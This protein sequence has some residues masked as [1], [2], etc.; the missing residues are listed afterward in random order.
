MVVSAD[1]FCDSSGI[2]DRGV[3]GTNGNN[4]GWVRVDLCIH[5]FQCIP[6]TP[7]LP[8]EQQVAFWGRR[9]YVG[10][11]DGQGEREAAAGHGAGLCYGLASKAGGRFPDIPSIFSRCPASSACIVLQHKVDWCFPQECHAD[12]REWE[13]ATSFRRS[14]NFSHCMLNKLV[15]WNKIQEKC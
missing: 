8:A 4:S 13:V 6:C 11:A 2:H 10:R 15:V 7:P 12:C 14:L 5:V 1:D 3:L 9:R